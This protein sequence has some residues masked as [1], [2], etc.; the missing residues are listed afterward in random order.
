MLSTLRKAAGVRQEG[1]L[2]RARMSASK[3]RACTA[4]YCEPT[5]AEL[6]ALA[7]AVGSAPSSFVRE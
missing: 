2:R 3:L 7:N 5:L 4:G 6:T 1:M